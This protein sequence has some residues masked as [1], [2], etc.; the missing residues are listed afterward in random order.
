MM[1]EGVDSEGKHF[2]FKE[3]EGE[4]NKKF[5]D[6]HGSHYQMCS[7]QKLR[8]IKKEKRLAAGDSGKN[9][10]V[11]TEDNEPEFDIA[12]IKYTNAQKVKSKARAIMNQKANCEKMEG[13]EIEFMTYIIA[14]HSDTKRK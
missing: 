3:C 8:R 11:R 14:N 4:D 12:G 7:G 1:K 9:K 13:Y 10:R 5:W 6:E 2:S